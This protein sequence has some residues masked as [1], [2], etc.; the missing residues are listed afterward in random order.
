VLDTC[1]LL[2][3]LSG[4]PRLTQL[5]EERL[6]KSRC[7][8]SAASIWEV[9]IK[10]QLGK[11]AVAPRQLIA[12]AAEAGFEF[13][14]MSPDHAAATAALPPLH[15]DPFDRALIA[16]A[17]WEGLRFL[18]ADRMLSAYGQGVDVL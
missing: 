1:V 9:A 4:D 7:L 15:R 8:V 6:R 16:Q 11:L 12:M 13:L 17:Q 10:H 18:T 14:A 5:W 3:W 2:W